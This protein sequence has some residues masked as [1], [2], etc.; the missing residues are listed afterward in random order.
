MQ[1]FTIPSQT[2]SPLHQ[3]LVAHLRTS[4][5]VT[6]LQKNDVTALS[7]LMYNR[8]NSGTVRTQASD[9]TKPLTKTYIHGNDVYTVAI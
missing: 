4:N 7:K 3:H 8:P 1:S 2:H 5:R 6:A 9:W